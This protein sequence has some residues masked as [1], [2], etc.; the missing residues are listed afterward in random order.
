MKN[1]I[2]ILLTVLSLSFAKTAS[3]Q[4]W[5]NVNAQV[6][7]NQLNVSAT[8][9]NNFGATVMC[10][11]NVIGLSYYGANLTAPFFNVVIPAGQFFRAFAYTNRM[12]PFVN[13]YAEVQCVLY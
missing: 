12:D 3:A 1:L 7:V 10:R 9:V 6:Q 13:G 11:G 2:A 8:V 5:F 4:Q